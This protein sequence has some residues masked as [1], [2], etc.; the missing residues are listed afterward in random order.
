MRGRE[1]AGTMIG[2]AII[3]FLALNAQRY[4][5][6]LDITQ[7]HMYTFSAATTDVLSR[8]K[9]PVRLT[10]YVSSRLQKI[11]PVPSEIGNVLSEYASVSRGKVSARVVSADSPTIDRQLQSLGISP[12][13]MNIVAQNQ[14][15][16]AQ[17]YSAIDIQ[18]LD[19]HE[20]LPFVVSTQDLEYAVTSRI[21]EA[22]S[23]ATWTVGVIVGDADRTLAGDYTIIPDGV[24]RYYSIVPLKPGSPIPSSLSALIVLGGSDLTAADLYPIDH[25]LMGGGRILFAVPGVAINTRTDLG[26]T[27]LGNLPI[28]RMLLAYGVKISHELVLDSSNKDFRVLRQ[29]GGQYAWQDFG[30]YPH[31]VSIEKQNVA[32]DNPITSHF[33][34]L[35]LLWPSPLSQIPTKGESFT[36]LVKSSTNAW[37]M[38]GRFDTNPS[39][40]AAYSRPASGDRTGQFTLAYAITGS[41]PS[42]FNSGP[43]STGAAASGPGA[44]GVVHSPLTRMVV[45]GDEDFLS[46]LIHYSGSTYNV[47]FLQNIVDWLAG[48]Q[49][50]LAIRAK[51]QW[52]PRLDRIADPQA[53]LHAY[54]FA[55]FIGVFL[56]PL[57]IVLY[58]LRRMRKRRRRARRPV[59]T[60]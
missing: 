55:Q 34:G 10:Y 36:P 37:L 26:A 6:R 23:G 35:D 47:Q 42:F 29:N 50:L 46:N 45:V 15:T 22:I 49:D 18:Y 13:Q 3:V 58:G 39:D 54:G 20:I 31:W 59:E 41:F 9:Q 1:A 44:A 14:Q 21:K 25:Y 19:R 38:S 60:R 56:V 7:N 17:V 52:D 48:N 53:K 5:V 4:S 12:Q 16:T 57:L 11:S 51:S 40:I 2:I 33:V 8:L 27:P 32:S 43:L 28:Y 24:G 30:P